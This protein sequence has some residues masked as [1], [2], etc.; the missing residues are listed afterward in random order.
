MSK[1]LYT[2]AS[3]MLGWAACWQ[4]AAPLEAGAWRIILTLTA[5]VMATIHIQDLRDIDGD[6]Q[7]GRRTA[8][9]VWGERLTRSTLTATIAFLPAVTFVLYDLAHHGWPAWVAWALSSIL[10]LAAALRLLTTAGQAADQRTYR[11]WEQWVTAAL[12]CAVLVI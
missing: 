1:N 5:C 12:A 9:L 8:P 3:T 11:T 4:I 10:A 2:A 7:A 6:R